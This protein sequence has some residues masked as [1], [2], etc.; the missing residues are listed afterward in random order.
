M[1][2]ALVDTRA[3]EGCD[4]VETFVE[5]STGSVLLVELWETAGHQ[6]AYMKWRMETGLMDAIG[7]F[8]SGAPLARTF[9]IKSDVW[10]RKEPIF[11]APQSYNDVLS[12]PLSPRGKLMLDHALKLRDLLLLNCHLFL[13]ALNKYEKFFLLRL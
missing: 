2:E 9:S 11:Q 7:G 1:R 6:Q 12:S 5:E 8:L 4:K 10:A 13:L 3:Y